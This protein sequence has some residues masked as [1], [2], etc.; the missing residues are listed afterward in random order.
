MTDGSAG[1]RLWRTAPLIGLRFERLF[2]HDG[3]A[4]SIDDAIL[5]HGDDGSEARDAGARFQALGADD[6]SA[7]LDY[8]GAL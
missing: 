3:R 2:L 5:A 6:R 7:L 8:I 1:S 4:R